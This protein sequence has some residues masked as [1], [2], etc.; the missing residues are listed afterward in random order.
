[1]HSDIGAQ[2]NLCDRSRISGLTNS[3]ILC[4]CFIHRYRKAVSIP[5]FANGNIQCLSDVEECIRKTGVHGVMSAGK[6]N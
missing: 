6:E 4:I 5:V 2:T 1:M 3:Q